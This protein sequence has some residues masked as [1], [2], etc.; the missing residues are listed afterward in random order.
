MKRKK[1]AT[2]GARSGTR[3]DGAAA[4]SAWNR[5]WFARIPPH[6]LALFRIGLAVFLL[7]YWLPKAPHVALMFSSEGVYLPVLIPWNAPPPAIAWI[8]YAALL[9][10]CGLLALG[11]RSRIVAPAVLL[12]Y[13]HHYF[14]DLAVRDTSFDR[15]IAIVLLL[16]CFAPLDRVWAISA[17]RGAEDPDV[18]AWPARLLGVQ[19][20][21]LYLGSGVW[22]LL[23]TSWH[24][25]EMLEMTLLGPWA[26]STGL[27]LAGLRLPGWFWSLSTFSVVA[28]ELVAGL[29]LHLR[30]L[31]KPTMLA[32][33]VFHLS[34]WI[35]LDIPE[36]MICVVLY[37]VLLDPDEVR[38]LVERVQIHSR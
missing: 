34:I 20:A 14:L 17:P 12:L 3:T 31:A 30:R 22:K 8:L 7:G 18:V 4:P 15:L 25:G 21:L 36:F 1:R 10:S 35:F 16:A 5:F 23:S 38:R 11:W 9:A 24:R 26:T 28:F 29:T 37:A 6:G 13:L 2:S 33:I 27:A 32:G 19:L